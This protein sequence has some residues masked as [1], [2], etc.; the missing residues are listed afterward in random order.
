MLAVPE[1]YSRRRSGSS[2]ST[3]RL[4]EL[5]YCNAGD[6]SGEGTSNALTPS[7]SL[8]IAI[9]PESSAAPR[10][11]RPATPVLAGSRP[12]KTFFSWKNLVRTPLN[13][14]YQA[15]ISSL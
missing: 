3:A 5:P 9:S 15:R 6:W 10:A 4:K 8:L 13:S 14:R 2:S 12:S 11:L 7:S 1:M